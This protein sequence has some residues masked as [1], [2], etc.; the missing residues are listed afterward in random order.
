MGISASKF[1][2]KEFSQDTLTGAAVSMTQEHHEIHEGDHYFIDNYQLALA[3]AAT[4]EFLITTPDTTKWGHFTFS[5][6]SS[7]GATIDVY[8]GPTG[9]TG[10]SAII[11]VNNNG[12]STNM[13]MISIIKDPTEITSDGAFAAGFLAGAG[14]DAGIASRDKEI[15]FQQNQTYL[16][17]LTATAGPGSVSWGFDWYEHTS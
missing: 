1:T 2:G 11:P 12:N 7:Q 10:G 13:S 15:I 5:M 16:L 14:R 3:N 17:R 4:I 6:W 9:I 8:K